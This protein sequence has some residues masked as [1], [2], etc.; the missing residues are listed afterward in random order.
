MKL[1]TIVRSSIGLA[2]ILAVAALFAWR[3]KYLPE[4]IAKNARVAPVRASGADK[5][6]LPGE[7]AKGTLPRVQAPVSPIQLP[8]LLKN[9]RFEEGLRGW[10]KWQTAQQFPDSLKPIAVEGIT[11]ISTGLRIE[12]P[13]VKLIGVK[14]HVRVVSGSV[15]RLSG[16][17]R[18]VASENNKALFGGRIGFW[19]LPQKEKQI[20][21]MSEYDKW[22]RKELVFTNEV[23]GMATVYA[24]MGYG[25]IAST[26][27]F[28]DIR[29]ERV[30]GG[31]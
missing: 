8:N 12:N 17:V 31:R 16:R 20:V 27:E 25:N 7:Q 13:H 28:T 6:A 10:G 3:Y 2:V 21:W 15:Y 18:S 5:A 24:H 19:L 22:W 4:Q 26:G 11:G 23:D 1:G 9:R 14:Q 29:L 30:G